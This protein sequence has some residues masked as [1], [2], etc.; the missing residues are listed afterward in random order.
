VLAGAI[1]LALAAVI[2]APIALSS[3][4][5]VSWAA[6]PQGLGRRGAVQRHKH[7]QRPVVTVCHTAQRL[8][9]GD[10]PQWGRPRWVAWMISYGVLCGGAVAA[11]A[12]L[13]P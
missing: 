3:G 2:V 6:S 9:D 4:D 8:E 1:A 13:A 5:L 10:I 7:H 11:G 12:W